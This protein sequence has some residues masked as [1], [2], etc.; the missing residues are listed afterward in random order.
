MIQES[1]LINY[2]SFWKNFLFEV[3]QV[4]GKNLTIKTKYWQLNVYNAL[5]AYTAKMITNSPGVTVLQFEDDQMAEIFLLKF[6]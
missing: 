3:D 6:C 2:R 1:D 4:T 5:L